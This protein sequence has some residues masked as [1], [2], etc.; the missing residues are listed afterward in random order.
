[1][2]KEKLKESCRSIGNNL[3]VAGVVSAFFS[4]VPITASLII[5]VIGFI[6]IGYGVKK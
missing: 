6:L 3:M 4:K 1:M 2:N 5:I